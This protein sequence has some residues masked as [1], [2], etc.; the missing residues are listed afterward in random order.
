MR[1]LG[2]DVHIK[3][4]VW[5]LL[6]ASGQTVETGKTPTTFP[7]LRR[8]VLR[9]SESEELVVGPGG[10]QDGLPRARHRDGGGSENPIVQRLAP[11]DDRVVSEEDG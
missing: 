6:D 9:L 10:R 7:E 11:A 4:T 3:T 5:H 8:L 2:L 1:Y